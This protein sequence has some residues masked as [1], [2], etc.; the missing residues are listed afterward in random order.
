MALAIVTEYATGAQKVGGGIVDVVMEPPLAEQ[1]V[2]FTSGVAA[3]Q[4]PLNDQTT[5][6]R[7]VV[8]ASAS[9]LVTNVANGQATTSNQVLPA[10]Q[11]EHKGVAPGQKYKVSFIANTNF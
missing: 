10:S 5:L 4:N 1:V 7:I 6:I 8:N 11:V 2:D 3:T 9:M